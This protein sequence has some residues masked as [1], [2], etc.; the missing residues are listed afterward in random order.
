MT[1]AILALCA[2]L[3][4]PPLHAQALGRL[5]F[6]PAERRDGATDARRAPADTPPARLDG[7]LLTR[8]GKTTLWLNGA[9]HVPDAPLHVVGTAPLTIMLG[10]SGQPVRPGDTLDLPATAF[11]PAEAP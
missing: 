6:T 2:V 5:F 8:S 3:L 9:A 1:R 4:S 10:G 7:I 11:A